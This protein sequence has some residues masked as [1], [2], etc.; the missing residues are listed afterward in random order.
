MDTTFNVEYETDRGRPLPPGKLK[1]I[2]PTM[3]EDQIAEFIGMIRREKLLK[4]TSKGKSVDSE[5]TLRIL[6]RAGVIPD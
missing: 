6:R 3:S 5:V 1:I 4:I 2:S